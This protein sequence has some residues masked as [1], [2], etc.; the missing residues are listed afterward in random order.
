MRYASVKEPGV[1]TIEECDIPSIKSN[2]VLVK[3]KVCGICT[4]VFTGLVIDKH[5]KDAYPITGFNSIFGHE[6]SGIIEKVGSDVTEFKVGDRVT[7]VGPGY[8]E[9]A[10]IKESS[11]VK[12]PDGVVEFAHVGE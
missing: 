4:H 6:G 3:V 10:V 1:I 8:Q 7:Y 2:E 11:M 5:P 12:I 9:Y